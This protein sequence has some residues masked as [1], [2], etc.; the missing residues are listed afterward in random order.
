MC[1]YVQ[2]YST[3]CIVC[4]KSEVLRVDVGEEKFLAVVQGSN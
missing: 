4:K 2:K 1:L 3:L